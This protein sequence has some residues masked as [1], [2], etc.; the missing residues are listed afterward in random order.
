MIKCSKRLFKKLKSKEK[1]SFLYMSNL[2]HSIT[3]KELKNS[4]IS[5]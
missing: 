1:I 5:I 4:I 2:K 3:D